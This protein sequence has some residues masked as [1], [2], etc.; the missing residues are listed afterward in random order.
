M[1]RKIVLYIDGGIC[2]Q[3]VFYAFG[4]FF[5]SKGCDV[6]YDFRWF[7]KCGKD[8]N[9]KF[10]R[11]FVMDKAFPNLKYKKASRFKAWVYRHFFNN[12]W[13]INNIPRHLYVGGYHDLRTPCFQQY[14]DVFKKNFKP[15]DLYLI[16]DLLKEIQNNDSCAVH[17]RRGDLAQYNPVYGNPPSAETFVKAI[18]YVI[19][20][21]PKSVFYFFSDEMNFVKQNIIP[22]LPK[23]IKYKL[24]DQNGSNK[25]YL[26]LYLISHAKSIIASHG[27][28][29]NTGKDINVNSDLLFV[30]TK[31]FQKE[32]V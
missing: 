19:K 21:K 6:E 10:D 3:M 16:S 7:R 23:N 12:K 4:L 9:G 1:K 27:S 15:V 2:S 20:Q 26:D 30:S 13:T 29:G 11:S 14:K 17:V 31:D 5:E 22:L 8:L 28:F 18:K 25:G 24:C 32:N